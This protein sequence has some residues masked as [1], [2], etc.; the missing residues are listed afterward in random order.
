M[1]LRIVAAVVALAAA[2]GGGLASEPNAHECH[3]HHCPPSFSCACELDGQKCHC[4]EV[5]VWK[6]RKPPQAQTGECRH[7]FGGTPTVP[8]GCVLLDRQGYVNCFDEARRV[9]R[10]VAYHIG[11]DSFVCPA[12]K[13]RFA[14]FRV[15]QNVRPDDYLKSGYH[16]GHLAPYAAMG[17]DRDGDGKYG[18][19]D[20]DDALTTMQANYMSNMSPQHEVFNSAGGLWWQLERYVADD[21]VDPDREVYVVAGCIFGPG[22]FDRVEPDRR[23][24]IEVPPLFFKVL[25]VRERRAESGEPRAEQENRTLV[26]AFLFPHQRVRH[27]DIHGDVEPHI[28]SIDHVEALSGLDLF[29]DAELDEATEHVGAWRALTK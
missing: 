8:D 18:V 27:G 4:P 22:T 26:V 23:P 6:S 20:P 1:K 3:C 21:V 29:P 28:V 5:G 12:R 11:V 15:D 19:E 24:S 25:L 10:W 2:A 13:G 9:P 17:G 16:R 7:C 14:T